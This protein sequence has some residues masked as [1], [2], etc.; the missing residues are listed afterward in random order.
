[1]DTVALRIVQLVAGRPG[2]A[3]RAPRATTGILL[4]VLTATLSAL[5]AVL[6][7][8][9][10]TVFQGSAEAL[11]AAHRP[12]TRSHQLI[13]SLAM[14]SLGARA[15]ARAPCS[16]MER[17]WSLRALIHL[18]LLPSHRPP[19]RA[20]GLR[21]RRLLRGSRSRVVGLVVIAHFIPPTQ[22]PWEA[23]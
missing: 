20:L 23:L 19:R 10:T 16:S 6:A 4:T 12:L 9:I 18:R 22:S 1:M 21:L 13:V 15:A 2:Y 17:V 8:K 11:T 7:Q 3:R 14:Q 5:M